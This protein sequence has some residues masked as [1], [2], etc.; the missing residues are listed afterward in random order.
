VITKGNPKAMNYLKGTVATD[1]GSMQRPTLGKNTADPTP[2]MT[3]Y[4]G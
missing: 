1:K 4:T 2:A 3:Q